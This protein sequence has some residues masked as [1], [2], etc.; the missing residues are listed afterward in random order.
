MMKMPA[1]P[2]PTA[3][4]DIKRHLRFARQVQTAAAIEAIGK[5]ASTVVEFRPPDRAVARKS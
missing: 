3:K 1:P 4:T 2:A 5:T